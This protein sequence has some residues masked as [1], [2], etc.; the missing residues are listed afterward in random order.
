MRNK[1]ARD[2]QGDKAD[3]KTDSSMFARPK[4]SE[5][6]GYPSAAPS[7]S[8]AAPPL[9]N[10]LSPGMSQPWHGVDVA[11]PIFDF[12]HVTQPAYPGELF[13][14]G[15]FSNTSHP[16]TY[17]GYQPE[18]RQEDQCASSSPGYPFASNIPAHQT[19]NGMNVS[20]VGY[21]PLDPSL[22]DT[23]LIDLWMNTPSGFQ[24]VDL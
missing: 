3:A 6:S 15:A 21:Q 12:A 11:D 4:F 16:V 13:A 22:S 10:S 5:S 18:Q 7:N 17:Q 2:D 1:R 19:E 24:Y 14:P 23:N 9:A 8:N 20:S